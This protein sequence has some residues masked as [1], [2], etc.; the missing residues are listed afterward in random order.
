VTIVV[1]GAGVV[2]VM[3]P[4]SPLIGESFTTDEGAVAEANRVLTA[5]NPYQHDVIELYPALAQG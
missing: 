3:R 1:D 4:G 5:L 2:G